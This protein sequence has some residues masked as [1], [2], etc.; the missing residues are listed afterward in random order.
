MIDLKEDPLKQNLTPASRIAAVE[1]PMTSQ[2]ASMV[3]KDRTPASR[4]L[5]DTVVPPKEDSYIIDTE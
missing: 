5:V 3:I 1:P 4:N 2:L